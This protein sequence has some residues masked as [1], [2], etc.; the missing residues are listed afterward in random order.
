MV[1]C[2]TELSVQ[3]ADVRWAVYSVTVVSRGGNDARMI[4]WK[5]WMLSDSVCSPHVYCIRYLSMIS[6]PRPFMASQPFGRV[7]MKVLLY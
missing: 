2:H 6:V 4:C 5:M 1:C 7:C 3:M